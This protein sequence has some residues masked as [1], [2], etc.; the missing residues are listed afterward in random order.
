VGK[1]IWNIAPRHL[2]HE[3][4]NEE[5]TRLGLDCSGSQDIR[6]ERIATWIDQ[7]CDPDALVDCDC[8]GYSDTTHFKRC[9]FC[10]DAEVE[11]D[12]GTMSDGTKYQVHKWDD[13]PGQYS[14]AFDEPLKHEVAI[15][16]LSESSLDETVEAIKK[17]KNE[18]ARN[19]HR[20]GVMLKEVHDRGL[21][22]LRQKDGKPKYADYG[23]WT[24][25]EAGLGRTQAMK[26]VEVASNFTEKEVKEIGHTRL[27]VALQVPPEYRDRLID[28]AR[29]GA[30]KRDLE[31]E[32]A[33]VKGRPEPVEVTPKANA[34]T[35]AMVATS[36]TIE[37]VCDGSS[38]PAFCIADAP[39]GE[40]LMSNDVIQTYR[41]LE[42]FSDGRLILQIER[43]RLDD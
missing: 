20:L 17:L 40:E 4:L 7:N 34:I 19:Y 26:C 13:T 43:K 37:L 24:R 22:R 27:A 35:L 25:S 33:V 5:L 3:V 42:G 12:D 21:W 39:Y 9:P 10:G 18:M 30:S 41:I 15:E 32:V 1:K 11:L 29:Q 31:R 28:K 36:R 16:V 38:E 8:G 14:I 2:N 23:Q 6:V